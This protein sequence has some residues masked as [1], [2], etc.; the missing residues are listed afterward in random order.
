MD[1]DI[2]EL[3]ERTEDGSFWVKHLSAFQEAFPRFGIH[4]A[5]FSKPY[6]SFLFSGQKTI[7]I[8][9][10]K[11]RCDPF[12]EVDVGDT[13]LIKELSG[14][15]CGIALARSV[16]FFDIKFSSLHDIKCKYANLSCTDSEFWNLHQG[17]S[18]ATLIKLSEIMPIRP[19]H[20]EKRDRRGWVSLCRRQL[21]MAL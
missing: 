7:D 2:R 20:V 13:I 15:I 1:I 11:N 8:R 12:G 9:L 4:L 3:Q 17:A 19:F 21:K 6:I 14:P 16:I 18:Y 10:S 5:V